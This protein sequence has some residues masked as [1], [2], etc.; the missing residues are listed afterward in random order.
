MI[1]LLNGNSGARQFRRLLTEESVKPG[2]GLDVLNAAI[3][4]AREFA[5]T[6]HALHVLIPQPYLYMTPETIPLA[7]EAQEENTQ[8]EMIKS[9]PAI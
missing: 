6:I 9:P 5:S 2:A 7:I 3:A 4:I 8:A 1:G